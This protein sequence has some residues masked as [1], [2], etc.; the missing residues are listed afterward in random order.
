VVGGLDADPHPVAL[1]LQHRDGDLG[2]DH[3]LLPQFPAEYEHGCPSVE[4]SRQEMAGSV[5]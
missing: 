3:E 5:D 2:A 4:V 1:H